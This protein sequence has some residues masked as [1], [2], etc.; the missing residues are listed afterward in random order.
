[1]T[2]WTFLHSGT[3]LWYLPCKFS[4][5]VWLTRKISGEM[6]PSVIIEIRVVVLR[7]GWGFVCYNLGSMVIVTDN[8]EVPFLDFHTNF[9]KNLLQF[10]IIS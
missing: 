4:Q 10:T 7:V 6:R 5:P 8:R 2:A 1:M 9:L 3:S